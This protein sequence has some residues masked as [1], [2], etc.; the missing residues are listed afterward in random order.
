MLT[1][2]RKI[3]ENREIKILEKWVINKIDTWN[4][5]NVPYHDCGGVYS[6]VYFFK[7]YPIEHL[8]LENYLYI[9]VMSQQ[10]CHKIWHKS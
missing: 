10:F 2:L 1:N 8:K 9:S 4:D 6:T 5:G 3:S 7:T